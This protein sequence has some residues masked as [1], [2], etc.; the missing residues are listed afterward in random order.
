MMWLPRAH[1]LNTHGPVPTGFRLAGLVG[2]SVPSYACFDITGL[3]NEFSDDIS[4]GAG[5]ESRRM[6]VC[7]SGVS[8]HVTLA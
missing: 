5:S 3:V 2:M 7:G 8:I 1:S 6:I 4:A